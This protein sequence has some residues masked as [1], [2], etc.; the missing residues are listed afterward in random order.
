MLTIC[1]PLDANL[2]LSD[3]LRR[4]HPVTTDHEIEHP[5]SSDPPINPSVSWIQIQSC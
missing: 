2:P 1:A 4:H 3:T 5:A